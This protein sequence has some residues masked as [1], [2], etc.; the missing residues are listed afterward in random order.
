MNNNSIKVIYFDD[1][2]GIV[3]PFQLDKLISLGMIKKFYRSGRWATVGI[4]QIRGRG[5]NYIG[6]ERRKPTYRR[7]LVRF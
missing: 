4:D 2:T 3:K 7:A 1:T 5:G 6:P